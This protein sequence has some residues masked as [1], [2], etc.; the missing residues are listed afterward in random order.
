MGRTSF[1]SLR[2][3]GS[4]QL[5]SLSILHP[6]FN[7]ISPQTINPLKPSGYYKQ[8]LLY[9]EKLCILAT[10]RICFFLSFFFFFFMILTTEMISLRALTFWS[11]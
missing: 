8:H 4:M 5:F 10:E 9:Q 11:L 2:D 3:F 7:Q 1:I 6:Q